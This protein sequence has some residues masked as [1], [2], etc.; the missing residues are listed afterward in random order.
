MNTL[1]HARLIAR[2]VLVWLAFS[3]GVAIASPLVKPQAMKL[4]CSGAGVIKLQPLTDN[5]AQELTRMAMDC[6]L[7][8]SI[9]APPP[10]AHQMVAPFQPLAYAT[11]AIPA[12]HIAERSA[13]ALPPRGPPAFS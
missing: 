9:S 5:D 10:V 7:C 8:M 11:Q 1:R 6:P 12:A 3:I 4:I 13:S 2:F